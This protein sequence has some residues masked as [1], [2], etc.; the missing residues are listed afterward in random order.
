MDV[1]QMNHFSLAL[2]LSSALDLVDPDVYNH[3]F[4]VAYIAL[5]LAEEAGYTHEEKQTV[6][7]AALYH[8]IGAISL[9]DKR[10]LL[11][12][13][14]VN[15]ESHAI[16]GSNFLCKYPL[17]SK[18]AQIIRYHHRAWDCGKGAFDGDK[19]IPIAAHLLH[20]SDRIAVLCQAGLPLN[21][22]IERIHTALRGNT[23]SLFSPELVHIWE[24][25]ASKK[26]FWTPITSKS[27]HN[28]L[29]RAITTYA[30]SLTSELLE[31]ILKVYAHIIDFRS[32]YTYAHSTSV[33][34]LVVFLGK[35]C[36]FSDETLQKIKYA[37]L[38]HDVGAFVI[39]V[40]VQEYQ[41]PLSDK[42]YNIIK[43][44]PFNS[45][46]VLKQLSGFQEIALW[47]GHHH[48]CLN[49]KGYPFSKKS[50]EISQSAQLLK[51]TEMFC[52]MREDRAYRQ[53]LSIEETITMLKGAAQRGEVNVKMIA[54]VEKESVRCDQIVL[55]EQMI[56]KKEYEEWRTL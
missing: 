25:V 44:H 28:I 41:G 33:A 20:L 42:E 3:H 50:D 48:E 43:S 35:Q 9:R 45:Y 38:L 19:K 56:C 17:F 52:A 26:M 46:F 30:V 40:E 6:L 14:V 36:G 55:S 54:L 49:G 5:S 32:P 27:V 22:Q 7:L 18:I 15:A 24:A 12:F 21:E 13:D 34:A 31:E 37:A 2:M 51:I 39:P 1:P 16:L 47:A 8:D 4:T 23:P 53:A 29:Q 11:A 10:G